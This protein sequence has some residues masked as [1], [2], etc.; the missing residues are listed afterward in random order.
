MSPY[1]NTVYYRLAIHA[2]ADEAK[3]ASNAVLLQC[4]IV[5]TVAGIFINADV[6]K[7]YETP[8]HEFNEQ[9]TEEISVGLG[10]A[11]LYLLPAS[12]LPPPAIVPLCANIG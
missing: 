10:R 2:S 3:K 7:N 4:P 8:Y 6:S 5:E 9:A 11:V 12:G 1:P